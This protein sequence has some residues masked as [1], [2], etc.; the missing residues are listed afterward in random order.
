MRSAVARYSL[1]LGHSGWRIAAHASTLDYEL[2]GTYKPLD[3]Q[4]KAHSA[5]LTATYPLICQANRN[6]NLSAGYEHRRYNDDMLNQAL[7]RH[8]LHA[9]TRG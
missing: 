5:G 7:R 9:L 4:G 1:P 8:R 6:L 3:A 2:G